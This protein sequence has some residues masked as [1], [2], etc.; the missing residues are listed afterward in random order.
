MPLDKIVQQIEDVKNLSI[1]TAGVLPPNPAELLATPKMEEM[2]KEAK[3]H[4]DY[5]LIDTPPVLSVADTMVL[6]RFVDGVILV[7]AAHETKTEELKKAQ[8]TLEK[9]GA[10]IQGVLLTKADLKN[11]KYYQYYDEKKSKA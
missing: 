3:K 1:L 6:S 9:V 8:K 4:F 7:V 5:I 2:L 10:K 11:Q